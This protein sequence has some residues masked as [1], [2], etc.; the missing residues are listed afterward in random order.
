MTE[1]SDEALDNA[2][3]EAFYRGMYDY[4][5]RK[6]VTLEAEKMNLEAT[7]NVLHDCLR[8]AYEGAEDD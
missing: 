8:E 6:I 7:I 4:A 5:M 2:A 1:E 3:A